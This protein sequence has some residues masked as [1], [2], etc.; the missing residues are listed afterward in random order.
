MLKFII[1]KRDWLKSILEQIFKIPDL[2]IS[3]TEFEHL[4]RKK[5]KPPAYTRNINF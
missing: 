5:T 2:D 3:Y 4:E 1:K